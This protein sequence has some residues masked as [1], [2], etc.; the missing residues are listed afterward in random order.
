MSTVLQVPG[1][2]SA[3]AVPD[4]TRHVALLVALCLALSLYG[5]GWGLPNGPYD[6]S[7]DSVAP[8]EPLA[9][10]KR[11]VF[12]EPWSSK[13]PPLHFMVLAAA[14]APYAAYLKL[15]GGLG[16]PSDDYPYGLA[17]P[18]GSLAVFTLIARLVSVAMGIGLVLVNYH[19]V[20]RLHGP[21]AGLIAGLLLASSYP[22]IHY[23]RNANIDV[24]HLF[25]MSLALWSLVAPIQDG[26][27]RHY[28]LLG[29]YAAAAMAT[30]DS[31]YALFVGLAPVLLVV[32]AGRLRE[33]RRSA[34]ERLAAAHGDLAWG[35]A[36]FL[37]SLA[38]TFNIPFNWQGFAAHVQLHLRRSVTGSY[39]IEEAGSP[40]SGEIALLAGYLDFLFQ[41]SVPT[42]LPLALAG[43]ASGLV[44]APRAT[45]LI[46]P[47]V[48]A[49]YVLFLRLH[50]THHLRYALPV[51]VLL[52]W[53]AARLADEWLGAGRRARTVAALV[54]AGTI[55]WAILQGLALGVLYTRDSRYA[56]E[57]WMREHIPPGATVL[58]VKPAYSLPRFPPGRKLVLRDLW[59]Y[60]GEQTADIQDVD[61]D[62]VVI[63]M[64]LQLRREDPARFERFFV[65]RGYRVAAEFKSPLP[66]FG[67]EI[68]ELHSINPR[69]V[70]F[71]RGSAR[72][73]SAAGRPPAAA[74]AGG[75]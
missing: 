8:L 57:A 14:Y 21:R 67:R 63:G 32:H 60:G 52:T 41:T 9:Y 36:A 7:N 72:L 10:A 46:V 50:S 25:W 30:K 37:L 35:L 3:S 28:V 2:A 13:Y 45:W 27:R 16:R 69:I 51:F 54:L 43:L 31:I 34:P 33:L 6:W 44:L 19:T 70:I 65:D 38:V 74:P 23:S 53:P 75:R 56:A 47:P 29:V 20:R 24:P 73:A 42:V 18:E 22:L 1:S 48:V 49:Y 26:R 17:D 11:L 66:R 64:G 15:T 40:V 68:I 39:L 4:S 5:I 55:G 71:E 61:P 12:G 58:G 62:Y 59:D